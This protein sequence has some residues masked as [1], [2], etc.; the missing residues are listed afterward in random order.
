[1]LNQRRK[2]VKECEL[3]ADW[4]FPL[5]L[6]VIKVFHVNAPEAVCFP[7]VKVLG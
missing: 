3:A 6:T 4:K 7:P 2:E 1:M 5:T